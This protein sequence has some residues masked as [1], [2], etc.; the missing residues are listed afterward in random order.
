MD[1][2]ASRDSLYHSFQI[3]AEEGGQAPG[4][5]GITYGQLSPHEIGE[6]AGELSER[7]RNGTYRPGPTRQVSIPKRGGAG[8][9]DGASRTFPTPP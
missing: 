8:H 5:D 2:I 1:V 9:R 7:I 6:I 4:P 3:L